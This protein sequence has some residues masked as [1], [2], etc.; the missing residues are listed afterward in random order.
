MIAEYFLVSPSKRSRLRIGILLDGLLLPR[1]FEQVIDHIQK[2]NFATIELLVIRTPANPEIAR[3]RRSKWRVLWDILS[4]SKRRKQLGFTIYSK[5]DQK[6]SLAANHPQEEIDCTDKLSGIET[7]K[8]TPIVKGFVHRFAP[9][10]IEEIR[11]WDLDVI[12]RFGFNVLR[13][14]IL[15]A[16]RYGIWSYHHGDNEFIR[17][18]PAHFWELYEEHKLSGVILQVLTEEIDAG[19]V[20]AKA[21]FPTVQGGIS[22]RQN[23]FTPY[24]GAVHLVIQKLYELHNYGWEH[25]VRHSIPNK[26]YQGKRKIYRAPTNW[27]LLRWLVPAL[28]AKSARRLAQVVTGDRIW[29]WRIAL[30]MGGRQLLHQSDPGDRSSF[31]WLTPPKGH[32]HA[33]PFMVEAHGRIW[34]FFEDYIYSES[35]GAIVCREVFPNGELGGIRTVLRRPYPLSYPFV[36]EHDGSYY[37]IPESASNGTVELSRATDFPYEWSLEKVLFRGRAVNT[38]VFMHE[39]TFWFLTT[40]LAPAG[41]GMCLC[42]FYSDRIDGEWQRH[43]ANPISMDVR[44]ARCGGRVFRH[45]GKLIRIS[46]DCSDQDGSSISFREILT[47]TK[48][49]YQETALQ[50][51]GLWSKS[52]QGTHTYD[53]CSGIEVIDGVSCVPRSANLISAE[54]PAE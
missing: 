7:I 5:F 8:I 45:D 50:S 35:K 22:A 15:T 16:A 19:L 34:M 12:L 25:L 27:E 40:L 24:W 10:D 53:H 36:F 48:T 17:G 41:D 21:L 18:G 30:R 47:L 31:K 33:D 44:D 29:L 46:Q 52:F 51:V 23:R 11:K 28:A 1:C 26:P 32:S 20:L 2:S 3:P 14:D 9:A 37:L 49:E 54:L 38:T 6:Y 43:P 39:D 4:D 42:I 13:G